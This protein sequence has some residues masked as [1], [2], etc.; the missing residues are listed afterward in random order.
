MKII[1]TG[2]L[3]HIGKPLT[4]ELAAQKGHQVT[5]VTSK[6]ERRKDIENLGA[7]AAVGSLEDADF[8]ASVFGGADALFAMEPPSHTNPDPIGYYRK[9]GENYAQAIE[10]SGVPRVVHLSSYG[11]HLETGSGLI[12]GSHNVENILNRLENVRVTHLRPGYFYYNLYAFVEMIKEA[13]IIGANYGGDDRLIL[14]SPIDIAAAAAEELTS[15]TPSAKVRYV[16]SD[17]RTCNEV[18]RV[19]GAAVGKPDLKWLTFTDEQTRENMEK[20]GAPKVLVA[21]LVE[22]FAGIHSGLLH[23]DYDRHRP[24]QT[25]KVKLEDFAK[26][27]AAAF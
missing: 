7:T 20:K 23:E 10:K 9:L 24:A 6:A 21:L 5:V 16:A 12:F 18:A 19:L 11:A 14:V 15:G 27:F 2:S 22:M 4:E 3:G 13:G 8:L 25:G 1:I 17:E 26:E